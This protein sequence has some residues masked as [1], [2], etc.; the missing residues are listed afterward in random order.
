MRIH[1]ESS[2]MLNVV[3][4]SPLIVCQSSSAFRPHNVLSDMNWK[5]LLYARAMAW[6]VRVTTFYVCC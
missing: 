1:K 2:E 3:Y 5:M 6:S 4:I